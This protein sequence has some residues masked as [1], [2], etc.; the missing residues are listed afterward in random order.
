MLDAQ[1]YQDLMNQFRDMEAIARTRAQFARIKATS[2][3]DESFTEED[4][5]RSRVAMLDLVEETE[6]QGLYK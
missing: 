4:I 2:Q 1:T 6:R 3:N 5:E